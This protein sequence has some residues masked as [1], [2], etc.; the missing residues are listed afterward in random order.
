MKTYLI[1]GLVMIGTGV[2]GAVSARPH[3]T[4]SMPAVIHTPATMSSDDGASGTVW[5]SE[6]D[7][8]KK[9]KQGAG[10]GTD[11]RGS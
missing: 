5:Q 11:T 3:S 9:K 7:K 4:S 1:L 2:G 10:S 6:G 8:K